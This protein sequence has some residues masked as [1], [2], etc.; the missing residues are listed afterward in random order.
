MTEQLEAFCTS[1]RSHVQTYFKF[2][3]SAALSLPTSSYHH[4]SNGYQEALSL[5]TSRFIKGHNLTIRE[6]SKDTTA[7]NSIRPLI[8][9]SKSI[10]LAV[11][12]GNLEQANHQLDQLVENIPQHIDNTATVLSLFSNLLAQIE[13]HLHEIDCQFND[14]FENEVYQYLHKLETLVSIKQWFANVVFPTV[15]EQK[16][17]YNSSA[18]ARLIQDTKSYIQHHYEEDL[19]LQA[20]ADTFGVSPAYLSRM[21]KLET[22]MTFSDYVIA[23]KINKAKEWLAHSDLSIKDISERLYYTTVQNFSRT[24]KQIT[25]VPPG[26]YRNKFR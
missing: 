21:F 19:S 8:Q 12:Q 9:Q 16:Q 7:P 18:S 15:I 20:V 10:V 11:I 24:F 5:L 22:K 2:T 17:N 4:I 26:K 25:G 23:F 3:M 13:H 6:Q 1:Y 14:L